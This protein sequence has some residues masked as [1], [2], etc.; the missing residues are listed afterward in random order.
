MRGAV[1]LTIKW[2]L[3]VETLCLS[4]PFAEIK[5]R[6]RSDQ[7]DIRCAAH[8]AMGSQASPSLGTAASASRTP[9]KRDKYV[10]PAMG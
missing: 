1:A 8:W 10:G 5:S 6:V 7:F 2:G 9:T 3:R 4:W